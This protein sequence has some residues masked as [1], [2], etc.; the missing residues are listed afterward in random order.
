MIGKLL[1]KF[2]NRGTTHRT[3]GESGEQVISK[4][5]RKKMGLFSK[6][7]HTCPEDEEEAVLLVDLE[8]ETEPT[9]D[10][11]GNLQ[12]YCPGGHIL[13]V[14]TDDDEDEADTYMQKARR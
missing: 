5:V 8:T 10:E 2:I 7:Y 1:A 12:Y 13:S 4:E 9:Y 14:E 11:D 6:K 3:Y